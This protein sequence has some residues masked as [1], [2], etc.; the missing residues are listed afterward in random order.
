MRHWLIKANINANK[1][2]AGQDVQCA[3]PE[4][5]CLSL[6]WSNESNRRELVTSI[7]DG[8]IAILSPNAQGQLSV[9]ETW[10]AH[11][12]EPW[13][14]AWDRSSGQ[15]IWTGGDDC[16]LKLWDRRQG[17]ARPCSLNKDFE[18]GVTT[19]ASHR[20]DVV[21]VGSYDAKV[22]IFDRRKLKQ[23]LAS[24]DVG[25]GVWRLKWHPIN[26]DK[27]LAACMHDGLKVLD[28]NGIE[29]STRLRFDE[30][31]SLA[32][33]ADWVIGKD[34]STLVASCSFYD[35]LMKLWIIP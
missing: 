33:G 16:K 7:S 18:G 25:G 29:F 23:S 24:H 13:I 20:D 31:E 10:N 11:D 30:H 19:V 22:R 32:Y 2:H 17:F 9:S 15:H 1:L 3:K 27:L 12:Y 21:A 4:K 34:K 28:F 5:L 35:H 14:V 26:N 8:I 6:D